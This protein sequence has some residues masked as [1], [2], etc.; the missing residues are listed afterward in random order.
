M[1]NDYWDHCEDLLFEFE[2]CD[3]WSMQVGPGHWPDADM[4]PIGHIGIR[5]CEYGRD[6]RQ[7]LFTSDEQMTVLTLWCM[8]RSLLMLGARL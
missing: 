3:E 8:F 4:L 1:T 2:K 7:S 5:S 6:D